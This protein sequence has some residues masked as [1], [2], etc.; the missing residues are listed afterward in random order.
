MATAN[1]TAANIPAGGNN[2]PAV[3]ST[4]AATANEKGNNTK[5]NG[6]ST[7]AKPATAP[8]TANK[9]ANTTSASSNSLNSIISADNTGP[10]A[11]NA[12]ADNFEK[13]LNAEFKKEGAANNNGTS[14]MVNGLNSR[15]KT[16]QQ[17]LDADKPKDDGNGGFF[18]KLSSMAKTAANNLIP[19]SAKGAE[20]GQPNQLEI[21]PGELIDVQVKSE[22]YVIILGVFIVLV[23]VI[24]IYFFSKT[25]NVS[26]TLD[27]MAMYSRYQSLSSVDMAQEP[28]SEPLYKFQTASSYNACHSG[29]QMFSYTSELIA[30]SV[31]KSG[32]RYLELNIFSSAYGPRGVPVVDSGFAR[33]E[34]KLM[35]N[36]TTFESVIRVI[37][38]NAFR[39]ATSEDGVPNNTD[40]LFIGLNLSTGGN[41]YC[42]DLMADI[43]TDYF[44]DKLLDAKY[45]FQFT[46]DF[47]KTP[48]RE[49]ENKVVIFSSPGFE[50]SRLE[51]LVNAVWYSEDFGPSSL[52][53]GAVA[54]T[55]EGF[56]SAANRRSNPNSGT[57]KNTKKNGKSAT[58]K[59]P[60]T[61]L[62]RSLTKDTP[63]A[64]QS[65]KSSLAA[66]GT[67]DSQIANEKAQLTQN[68]RS[69]AD[70]LKE[71]GLEVQDPEEIDLEAT[72]EGNTETNEPFRDDGNLTPPN[73]KFGDNTTPTPTALG[74]DAIL[75][76]QKQQAQIMRIC[77]QDFDTPGFDGGRIQAFTQSGGLCIVVPHREGDYI[78]RN[79]DPQ[80]AF[81]LGCQFVAMN[82]QEIDKHM[83]KYITRFESKAIL[84]VG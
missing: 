56:K 63:G 24:L 41:T 17:T 18:N 78:T 73:E 33:G 74:L 72:N 7:N 49:L 36:T 50:G 25:F 54:G 83:D 6:V 48:L 2:K 69:L 8:P 37:S 26:R 66:A 52:T 11:K 16:S 13:A 45:A 10:G 27:K 70:E 84:P 43:L 35:L 81:E 1:K 71:S 9:P 44:R 39:V 58:A 22:N 38:E 51:E 30:K 82:F 61:A 64:K 76:K 79:Y 77:S 23:L 32:A 59:D 31:L 46:A 57:N 53:S 3:P 75:G 60:L 21:E 62:T 29:S 20:L 12:S 15:V 42:L 4:A 34:W 40:P 55:V 19:G 14:K 47:A 65:N 5:P 68:I 28:A 80:Q 67:S